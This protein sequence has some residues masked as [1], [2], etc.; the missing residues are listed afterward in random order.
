MPLVSGKHWSGTIGVHEDGEFLKVVHTDNE[1][2]STVLHDGHG[3]L[4]MNPIEEDL[5]AD[6]VLT[7]SGFTSLEGDYS[8]R[9]ML[10]IGGMP[11]LYIDEKDKAT[12]D[13]FL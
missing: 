8:G 9:Y 1:G 11:Y 12:V 3:T 13:F 7:S 5:A 4:L 6:F 10:R 2:Y